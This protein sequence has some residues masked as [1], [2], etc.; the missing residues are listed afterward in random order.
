MLEDRLD[1]LERRLTDNL[2]SSIINDKVN[3]DD[4]FP[5]PEIVTHLVDLFFQYLNSVFPLIHRVK[6]KQSIADGTVSKPLLW[7]VMAIGAR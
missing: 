2:P 4:D 5:S 1:Q 6:L 7:S 3:N